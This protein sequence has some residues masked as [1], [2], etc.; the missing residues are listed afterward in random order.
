[1]VEDVQEEQGWTDETMLVLIRNFIEQ[2]GLGSE[3]VQYLEEIAQAENEEC[4][5][6]EEEQ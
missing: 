1:M 6:G 5:I 2:K 3:L 4:G